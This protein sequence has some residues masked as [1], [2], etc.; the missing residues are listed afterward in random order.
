MTHMV[1]GYPNLEESQSIF[2]ILKEKSEYIE[3]QFPFSDPIADWPVIEKANEKAL[4]TGINTEICFDFVEK[5]SPLQRG[6]RGGVKI[7]IM[8]Y[9]NIV[10]NYWVEAFVKKA[11]RLWVYWFIIPD[12]PFDEEDWKTFRE[13]CKKYDIVFTEIVSPITTKKRLE[14]IKN[15]NPK[16]IYAI[17]QNMTTGS[18]TQFWEDFE[19]YMKNLKSIFKSSPLQM[20]ARGGVAIWVWFWVKTKTD[21]AKVCKNTDFAIIGSEF[22]K[23]YNSWG[24]QELKEYLDDITK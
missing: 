7:L 24:I 22:I 11:K 10:I 6:V 16:L 5:N 18:T 19:E 23:K 8:T 15:L 4:K 17:S 12:V 3:I 14:D 13:L 2:D 9:Y 21:V 20:G 1:C